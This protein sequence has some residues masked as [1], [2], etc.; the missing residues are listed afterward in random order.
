[1]SPIIIAIPPPRISAG[2]LPISRPASI[3]TL[4]PSPTAFGSKIGS[5]LTKKNYASQGRRG[6][7]GPNQRLGT[8]SEHGVAGDAPQLIGVGQ[9]PQEGPD[10]VGHGQSG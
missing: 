1:M 3:R 6:L 2:G 7:D 8:P 10:P 5:T 4:T 9:G